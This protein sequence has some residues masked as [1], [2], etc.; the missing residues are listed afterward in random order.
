MV[1]FT[2]IPLRD[3][4]KSRCF[5]RHRMHW[6]FEPYGVCIRQSALVDRGARPVIY[7]AEQTWSNLCDADRPFFQWCEAE[8]HGSEEKSKDV[9]GIDWSREQ[10]WRYPGDL[11]LTLF[12]RAEI[13]VFVPSYD[14]ARRIVSHSPWGVTLWPAEVSIP[15]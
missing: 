6:D 8:V 4:P 2:A 7:G 14:E 10:E 1:S 12:E 15:K 5:R 11:D 3:L 9:V 13:K